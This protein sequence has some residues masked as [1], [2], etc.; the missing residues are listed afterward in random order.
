MQRVR[1]AA[2]VVDT[3]TVAAIGPGLLALVGICREDNEDDLAWTVR[4]LTGLRIFADGGGHLARDVAEAGGAV[5]LVSQV[6]LCAAVARGRRPD[7]GPAAPPA[8]AR[9]W[10]ARLE[11]AVRAALPPGTLVATGRFGAHMQVQL[12]ND[13][14][15]TIWLDSR[16]R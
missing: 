14:P 1:A 6:T 16:R 12:V 13:G 3:E 7:L 2:V 4:K 11:A 9:A 8:E 15:V 5:L 10:F